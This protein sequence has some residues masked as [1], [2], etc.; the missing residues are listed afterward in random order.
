VHDSEN[1]VQE[2]CEKK[3]SGHALMQCKKEHGYVEPLE[4]HDN[5]NSVQEHCE[6][7]HSGEGFEQCVV[8]H[9]GDPIIVEPPV[10]QQRALILYDAPVGVPMQ[11]LGLSQ[12]IMLKN[13]LG[14][15][16][17]DVEM[18]RVAEYAA[19]EV[20]SYDALFYLGSYYNNP[21]SESFLS[22]ISTTDTT[23]V[24]F[25]YNLWDLAWNT[26]YGFSEKFG[27]NLISSAG[28]NSPP[29]PTNLAPG[30]FDAVMYKDLAFKKFYAYDPATQAVSADPDIGLIE[31]SDVTKAT[32]LVEIVN[33][34]TNERAPYI[35]NSANFWYVADI[36]F[37]YIGPRDRYVV[38]SDMLHE[39]LNIP[40]E[41]NHRAMIRFED[42]S[43]KTSSMALNQ[44]SDY[45]STQ[46][47]PFTMAVVPIYKDPNGIY[48]GGVAEE[49]PISDAPNLIDS[50]RY[51]EARGGHVLMHGLTH[52]YSDM[53]NPTSGVTA[54][55]YEFWDIVN[56]K[57]VAEDSVAWAAD[58]IQ[59]GLNVFASVG[60]SPYVWE[61]PHYHGSPNSYAAL[62]AGKARY[63]R[64]FYYTSTNP[65]LNLDVNDPERDFGV[66]QFFPFIIEVDHYGQKVLPENLG[67]FV[68]DIGE[69][70][71]LWDELYE[72][73]KYARVV[74][75]GFASFY[76]HPFWLEPGFNV[77]ALEDL[78]KLVEG[79]NGLGYEWVVGKELLNSEE[80]LTPQ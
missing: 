57:P 79:I 21:S 31:I 53:H 27:I 64:A 67:N 26:T 72:N 24:W 1:T 71:V 49:I 20:D 9:G 19:G 11:K 44:L 39:I 70:E 58:R 28:F 37:S 77:P 32:A 17:M 7:K 34:A 4:P 42:I 8:G 3:H 23:V 2:H 33:S 13:L 69:G 55:D 38:F 16:S 74:R 51:A 22:D 15:F 50:L 30:F 52:Q 47:I 63:E 29:S 45:L 36:P 73:A 41:E 68:F 56:N 10:V 61:T 14:H 5:E 54:D 25:K 6:K 76:F 18:K 66:G 43:S 60:I 46:Q 35:T 62:G 40:H 65:Q 78:N 75:D 80:M 59:T 48:N 12:A